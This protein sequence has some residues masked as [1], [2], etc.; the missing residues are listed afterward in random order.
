MVPNSEIADIGIE[1][2][3]AGNYFVAAY[4]PFSCWQEDRDTGF[5]NSSAAEPEPL[6]LYVH[7]PFCDIRCLYCYYL[8][9]AQKSPDL[10]DQYIDTL[11]EELRVYR[12]ILKRPLCFVYF[13]GGTPS[14]LSAGQIRRLTAGVK[15]LFPWTEAEE[16]S[17]ECAP[18]S[19]TES[20][21][22]ALREAG[23]TR[24]S[25]GV[26]QLNNEVLKKNGRVHLVEDVERA[27]ATVRQ[28]GFDV[29]N[30]DLMVGLVGESEASF[31][32]S[33]D[34]VLK[35]QPDSV[36]IY[37]LEV[38]LNTPLYRVLDKKIPA[39]SLADWEVK[40]RRLAGGFSRLESA[41]YQI[42]SAYTAVRSTNY[43][44]FVYQ[45]AQ[46]S[47]ADLLGIGASAFSYLNGTHFQNL[48]SLRSYLE[49]L[50]EGRLPVNRTYS[51]NDQER[52]VREFI[53]QLK[54]GEVSRAYFLRKFD[55]DIL[56]FFNS[57]LKHCTDEGWI[58]KSDDGIQLTSE[59][60]LR[61]DRILPAFY[62]PEHQDIRYS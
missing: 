25:L 37:Q 31:F 7:I 47:G 9:Y 4:P 17:F 6:G 44:K 48:V 43:Q 14:L 46:Y 57:P 21:L 33:L 56:E 24:I 41:G 36:T 22:Q 8:S 2:P 42:R 28:V 29:V 35:L 26:Q 39:D 12:D 45:D 40:R 61:V 38:P 18:K 54:L 15:A 59:G 62:L 32:E 60:L 23:V 27:Y 10:I 16:I 51:L 1:E 52:M 50:D 53:L 20:K 3:V 19:V 49:R 30:I 5:L 13:G 34:R 11:I 58:K 55:M